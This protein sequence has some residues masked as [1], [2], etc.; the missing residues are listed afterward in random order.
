MYKHPPLDLLHMADVVEDTPAIANIM[1]AFTFLNCYKQHKRQF[2]NWS[3]NEP[4]L[5]VNNGKYVGYEAVK[6]FFVDYNNEQT[7]WANEVMRGLYPEEL[8]GKS[9]EEIW[10]AMTETI[11]EAGYEGK[12]GFQM[13]VATD[14]YH[15]KEDGK[16]YGL[17]NNQPKT[18]DQLYEFYLHIIKEFPFVILEDPFNEDDYDTTA[19]LT[20]D[21]VIQIVGDDLFTTNIRRVAYGVTKGA[22]NTV[23]LKV[24]QIGTIS[25]AL[26]MIQYAYKFGYAVMPSDSRGEGEAIADYAVGINAGSVREC[27][28]GPRANRFMEIEAELGKTA[29]FL[30]AR[31]LKGFKNQQRADALERKE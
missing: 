18:K 8:G 6:G 22:A 3:K 9:D 11:I 29:K 23:L 31:G 26:E 27:G 14:T 13:D 28:I 19:A 4:T 12:A 20:K 24:N 7:K 16:Y 10:E 25:E 5:T 17:F 21:S 30:G 15:N 1:G 2:E